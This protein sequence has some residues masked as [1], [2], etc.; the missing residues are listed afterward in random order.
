MACLRRC[1]VTLV[2][3][4]CL[5]STV[6]LQLSPQMACARRCKI[7]LNV[8]V[9]PFSTVHFQMLTQRAWIRASKVTLVAFVWLFS[10]VR[11]Q[12]SSQTA[13]LCSVPLPHLA[14][15]KGTPPSN[16]PTRLVRVESALRPQHIDDSLDSQYFSLTDIWFHWIKV[17]KSFQFFYLILWHLWLETYIVLWGLR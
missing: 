5:F 13:C 7:I 12:M 6:F 16:G 4:V 10:T 3:F 14:G 17:S 15:S 1:I 8:F 11:F 2:A 9:W